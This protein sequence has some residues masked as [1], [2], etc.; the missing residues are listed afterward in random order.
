MYGLLYAAEC[1]FY[2]GEYAEERLH[3]QRHTHQAFLCHNNVWKCW[4]RAL[5]TR[6]ILAK[7]WT[8]VMSETL[9]S[10]CDI[11]L[12]WWIY[13]RNIINFLDEM[14]QI[15]GLGTSWPRYIT[16]C[17]R[18]RECFFLFLF[19]FHLHH[20]PRDWYPGRNLIRI[21]NR[22]LDRSPNRI[23]ARFLW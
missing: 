1:W 11:H 8:A 7:F 13:L 14:I 2:Q 18:G 9:Q 5:C 16:K 23:L 6:S 15:L 10:F 3:W 20:Y 21:L 12:T 17:I 4:L 19:Y 22:N